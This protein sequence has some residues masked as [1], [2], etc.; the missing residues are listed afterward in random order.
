VSTSNVVTGLPRG[1]RFYRADLHVHSFGGSH[2][3]KDASMTPQQIVQRAIE[4]L[5]VLAIADHNEISNV[6]AA[7]DAA[8]GRLL[9]VPAVELSTSQGHLLCYLPTLDALRRFHAQLDLADRG[10]PDSRCRTAVFSASPCWI[11]F[12]G[13]LSWPTLTLKE[14]SKRLSRASQPT[15]LMCFLI[16]L[17]SESK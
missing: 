16:G 12:T 1:A 4:G 9:L 11:S 6:E 5:D 13:S 15:R 10:T 8:V 17:L 14:D 2:D 3:V 7:I